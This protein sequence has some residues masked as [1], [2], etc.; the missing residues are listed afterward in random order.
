MGQVGSRQ[1]E[2]IKENLSMKPFFISLIILNICGCTTRKAITD[3]TIVNDE[4]VYRLGE[5]TVVD[6]VEYQ[7]EDG[8]WIKFQT[9]VAFPKGFMIGKGPEDL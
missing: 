4:A 7:T 6:N 8:E 3:V 2:E 5:N 1:Y 9:P